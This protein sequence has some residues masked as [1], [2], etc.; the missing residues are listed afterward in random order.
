MTPAKSASLLSLKDQQIEDL[1]RQLAA[2][3]APHQDPRPDYNEA[4]IKAQE[5]PTIHDSEGITTNDTGRP[6]NTPVMNLPESNQV[7]ARGPGRPK[8][9]PAPVLETQQ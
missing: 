7:T 2:L 1:K 8:N 3:Q 6:E 9:T 4:M 5:R